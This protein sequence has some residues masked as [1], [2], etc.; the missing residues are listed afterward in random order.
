MYIHIK[1]SSCQI[2]NFQLY[3]NKVGKIHH[4]LHLSTAK[5]RSQITPSVEKDVVQLGL[6]YVTDGRINW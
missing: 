6:S 1:S 4:G 2:F 5:M 3:L